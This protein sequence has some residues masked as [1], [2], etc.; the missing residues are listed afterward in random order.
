MSGVIDTHIDDDPLF[1]GTHDG[2]D[3]S[4]DLSDLGAL[5]KSLGATVGVYCENETQSS[6]GL[7]TAVTD[8]TVTVAGTTWDNGDTYNI[9]KTATKDSVISTTGVDV[10]R[11]W[12]ADRGELV[13]GWRSEDVDLDDHR[14]LVTLLSWPLRPSSPGRALGRVRW[15][16][17]LTPT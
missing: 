7:I 16:P 4:F 8:D 6:G 3:S 17:R 13:S 2:S 5:F 10:S 12:K 15:R 1:T 9:Y 14:Q 11:G